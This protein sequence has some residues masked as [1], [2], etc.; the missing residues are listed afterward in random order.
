[1]YSSSIFALC[2]ALAVAHPTSLPQIQTSNA[3]APL[4]GRIGASFLSDKALAAC[5]RA[6]NCET[7][8]DPV[9]GTRIRF[10][11]GMEPG[12]EHYK[13]EVENSNSTASTIVARDQVNTNVVMSQNQISYGH[14]GP[15]GPNGVIHHLYDICHKGGCDINPYVVWSHFAAGSDEGD[16]PLVLHAHA[17]YNGWDQRDIFVEAMVATSGEGKECGDVWWSHGNPG[18]AGATW[19]KVYE[20]KQ[21]N[22]ISLNRYVGN[23]LQGFMEVLVENP[24]MEANGC[25]SIL[26]ALAGISGIFGLIPGFEAL[27]GA[28]AFFGLLTSDCN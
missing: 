19:G 20:C 7:Y 8:E 24:R 28:S 21:S 11:S 6:T 16:M 18:G 3:T 1:M 12:S 2:I 9:Y 22:Y 4:G 15:A 17:Q 23:N 26:G 13:R 10:I 14:T 5:V 27:G 25:E